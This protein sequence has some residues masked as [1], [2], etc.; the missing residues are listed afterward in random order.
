VT[1]DITKVSHALLD[2]VAALTAIHKAMALAMNSALLD[3]KIW[4]VTTQY[5]GFSTAQQQG[6]DFPTV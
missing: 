6:L 3:S 4:E 2:T 5:I 1:R